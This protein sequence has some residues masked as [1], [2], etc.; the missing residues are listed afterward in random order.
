LFLFKWVYFKAD[1]FIDLAS[2]NIETLRKWGYKKSIYLET[3][4]VDN[5]IV[6]GLDHENLKLKYE[7]NQEFKI[8][9]LARVEKTKGIYELISTYN[10]L[11]SEFPNISLIIAGDGKE[12]LKVKE[13]AKDSKDITFKGFVTGEEKAILFKESH[14]FFFPSYFEGMPNSVLEAISCGLPVITRRVGGLIDFFKDNIHGYI[15]DSKDSE[16]YKNLISL[17]IKDTDL[18]QKIAIQNFDYGNT[19]FMA[20]KVVVR[21][22]QIY[23]EILN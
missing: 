13:F 11:K 17:L 2:T 9:F 7:Q 16:I 10:L 21:V 22:E 1:A 19:R 6:E 8:L 18:C 23:K 14:L 3:T 12:L 4:V 5:K 20:D 15:T